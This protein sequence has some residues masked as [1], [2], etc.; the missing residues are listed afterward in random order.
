MDD[1]LRENVAELV[2]YLTTIL[3][4]GVGFVQ[5]QAPVI[6]RQLLSYKIITNWIGIGV[7]VLIGIAY[8]L[9]VRKA[10][11]SDDDD[12][13]AAATGTG[14]VAVPGVLIALVRLSINLVQLYV[15]PT[16]FL[17]NYLPKLL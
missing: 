4:S 14:I 12:W 13:Y 17:I 9:V 15:A 7:A 3:Q 11:R 6:V 8:M 2:A 16:V 5:E 10:I 1:V